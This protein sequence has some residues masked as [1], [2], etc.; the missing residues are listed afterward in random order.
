M[1][2][3]LGKHTSMWLA[4]SFG[5]VVQ[6]PRWLLRMHTAEA[7]QCYARS[8]RPYARVRFPTYFL[9]LRYK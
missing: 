8:I 6:F 5:G 2:V 7:Q 1:P 4:S 3:P 9:A